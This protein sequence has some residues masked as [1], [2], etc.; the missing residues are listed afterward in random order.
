MVNSNVTFEHAVPMAQ[1]LIGQGRQNWEIM[2]YPK[3]NHCPG[4]TYEARLDKY[5]RIFKLFEETLGSP[6]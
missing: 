1:R 3:E 5:G 6:S 2:S 4:S